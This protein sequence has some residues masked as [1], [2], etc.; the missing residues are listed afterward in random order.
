MLPGVIEVAG[1]APVV[2]DPCIRGGE[3]VVKAVTLGAS[4]VA[5]GRPYA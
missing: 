4:A 1:G 3:H 5:V 2:F